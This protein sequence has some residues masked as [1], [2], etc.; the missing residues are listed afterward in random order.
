MSACLKC[1]YDAEAAV[2]AS[3]SFV[4]P[5]VL[6]SLNERI[7][8]GKRGWR[9]RRVREAWISDMQ[10]MRMSL[11]VR[12]RTRILNKRRVTITRLFSKHQRLM[13]KANVDTKACVDAMVSVGLLA[14]DS[15]QWLEL[16]VK[17]ER[18]QERGTRV[19]IEEL[20]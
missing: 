17:Q 8:N 14:D 7:H 5:R 3:W 11:P 10:A 2:V 12:D 15:P 20:T 13:D 19:S 18:G 1:G 16:H 9:Y 6:P 4:I